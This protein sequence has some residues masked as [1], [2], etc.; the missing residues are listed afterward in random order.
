MAKKSF[1]D[2][3]TPL[4]KLSGKK[5]V[6]TVPAADP[7]PVAIPVAVAPVQK[8]KPGRPKTKDVKNTCKFVNVAV[9]TEL[10]EKWDDIKV[11]HGSNLTDYI[12]MLL[13]IDLEANYDNYK[14]LAE[15]LG[16]YRKI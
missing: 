12:T 8:K 9:P 7:E 10:L 13:K 11:V 3:A 4:D 2:A 5:T 1:Y 15:S 6:V 14:A 16:K